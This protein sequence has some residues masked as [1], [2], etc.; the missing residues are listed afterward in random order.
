MGDAS[1]MGS[2]SK[3]QANSTSVT[4][5]RPVA[6]ENRIAC[7]SE[8][9]YIYTYMYVYS[10]IY[11]VKTV[12]KNDCVGIFKER[13]LDSIGSCYRIQQIPKYHRKN[14]DHHRHLSLDALAI[15]TTKIV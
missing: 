14:D 8:S 13:N 7:V 12:A 11:I 6:V 9:I 5:R 4:A 1:T 2:V 3:F 10:N 15:P